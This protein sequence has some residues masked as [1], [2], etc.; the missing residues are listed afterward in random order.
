MEMGRAPGGDCFMAE[1]LKFG[2]PLVHA[3]LHT[4]VS[5]TWRS[6]QT[7][8]PGTEVAQWPT[9]WTKGV[10]FPLSKRKGDR[11]HKN[12]WRGITLLSVGFK[13]VARICAGRLQR[14]SS[15]WLNKYQ[16]GFRKGSGVDDVQQ[17]TRSLIEEIT[18]SVHDRVF[19]MRF[20]DLEK[21]YPKVARHGLWKLLDYKG[22]PPGFI[23]IFQGL[24]N[25][26]SSSVRF[27]GLESSEFIPDRGLREGCPSSPILFNIYHHGLNAVPGVW[28]VSKVD[29][30]I[31][32]RRNDRI[33]EG[34]HLKRQLIG[35]LHMQMTQASLG[36]QMKSA[37]RKNF[38]P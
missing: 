33:E 32:K 23:K 37:K 2:G 7:A 28:W 21:A 15:T 1:Y 34:R 19:S 25:H 11:Q 3:Q 35:T 8:D 18:G 30:K 6:A 31:G 36:K 5:I 9:A 26:S 22:C 17:I 4:I 16:F 24:H 12:T 20:F 27:E 29:G 38:F 13:V 14:W 10:V